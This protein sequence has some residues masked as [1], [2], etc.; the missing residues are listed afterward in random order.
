MIYPYPEGFRAIFR[1]IQEL[2]P[3]SHGKAPL[4]AGLLVA[5]SWLKWKLT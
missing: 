2:Q 4:S 3:S 5:V 1:P